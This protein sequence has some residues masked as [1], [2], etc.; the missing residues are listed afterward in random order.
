MT[1]TPN[2]RRIRPARAVE[3]PRLAELMRGR[4][5]DLMKP[6]AASPPADI[7][8]R[9][10]R[11]L[12]DGALLLA[13]DDRQL[14]GMAALDLDHARLLALYLDPTRARAE[15]ARE[16]VASVEDTARAFGIQRLDCTVK[17]RAWAF[18]ERMGYEAA[19]LPDNHQPVDL[20][21]RLLDEATPW[22]QQVASLHRELGIPSNYGVKHRLRLVPE[23]TDRVSIGSDIFNRNTELATDAAAAWKAMQTNARRQDLDLRP[24]SGYRGLAYQAELIRKKLAAGRPINRILTASAA[25]GYSE[26]HSGCALD[27]SAPGVAPLSPDFS[28]TRAYEWLK[29]CAGF[30]GFHESYPDHNRHGIEWEPWHWCYRSSKA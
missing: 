14:S 27:L 17:P 20:F 21:K 22:Q 4:L 13:I 29:A 19:G 3:L 2:S 7:T 26:H 18:M 24:V 9:L 10:A 30:H 1:S 15:T 5:P 6:D 12:P 16:L 8:Q 28:N 23:A 11:L 25:P